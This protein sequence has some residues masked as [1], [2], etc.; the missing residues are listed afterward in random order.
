MALLVLDQL[1]VPL[2][3]LRAQAPLCVGASASVRPRFIFPDPWGVPD[4]EAAPVQG[5]DLE[6]EQARSN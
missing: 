5:S 1:S 3:L 4:H 6:T 2:A